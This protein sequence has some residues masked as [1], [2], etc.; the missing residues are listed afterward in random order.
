MATKPTK[1]TDWATDGAALTEATTVAR[2]ELGWQTVPGNLVTEPGERPNLQQQ[3]YWQLAVH[4]WATYFEAATDEIIAATVVGPA[5]ATAN[6]LA[7]YDSITGKIIKDGTITQDDSGNLAA[8]G[9]I[10]SHTI[11]GGTGTLALASD[12]TGT[13]SGTNTGDQTFDGLSPMTTGGDLIY[14]GASGAGTRLANGTA[15][16]VLTSAGTTLAPTWETP[17]GG[18]PGLGDGGGTA[19]MISQNI[20]GATDGVAGG[21]NAMAIGHGAVANGGNAIAVGLNA[22]APA[23]N[24][25]AI[26]AN[27]ITASFN[28]MAFGTSAQAADRAVAVGPSAIT[29]GFSVAI[30]VD[31][32]DAASSNGV[33]I[34]YEAGGGGSGDRTIGIGHS[35]GKNSSGDDC[36]LLGYFAGSSNTAS[37]RLII[38]NTSDITTPLIDGTFGSAGGTRPEYVKINGRFQ[39]QWVVATSAFTAKAGDK[40]LADTATTAAFTITLPAGV[41]GDEV[42]IVD[43]ASNWATDNLTIN[44]DGAETILGAGTL[45]LTT[46]DDPLKLVFFGTNW[47]TGR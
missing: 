46:N 29:G 35:A 33:W 16:Q 21:L 37:D 30:G 7:R 2:H 34:G 15:G 26:G 6:A 22:T 45:V 39:T 41:E 11:P 4:E 13:N 36:V 1:L 40:I 9:T 32:G 20:T 25:V 19:A 3:N 14:G 47:V 28:S 31:S 8:V 43:A 10:N 42:T 5:G 23:T 27:A 38:E 24:C 12:I 44:P 18:D 17:S